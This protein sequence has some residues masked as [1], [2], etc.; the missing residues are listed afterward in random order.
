M[1]TDAFCVDQFEAVEQLEEHESSR[2]FPETSGAR[3][4]DAE[5]QDIPTK[6]TAF[7]IDVSMEFELKDHEVV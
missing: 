5:T 2:T 6:G 7:Q 1:S 3:H 4:D